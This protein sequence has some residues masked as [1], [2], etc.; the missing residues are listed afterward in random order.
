MARIIY[1]KLDCNLQS[2]TTVQAKIDKIDAII[3][4]LFTTALTSVGQGNVAE[5]ELDTG[6]TRTNV[7]YTSLSQVQ[8]AIQQYENIRQRY[9]NMLSPRMVRLVDSKNFRG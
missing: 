1:I 5:Y 3:D 9:V 2:A 7:K 6:Q 4:S 8:A